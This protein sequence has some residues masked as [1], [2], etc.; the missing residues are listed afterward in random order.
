MSATQQQPQDSQY[1]PAG[2]Q[3]IVFEG[4]STLNTQSARPS[5]EDDQ[6][7]WMDGFMP[8]GKSTARTMWDVGPVIYS[9]ASG[10]H[11]VWFD[12]CNIGAVPIA[13]LFLS[14]GSIAVVYTTTLYTAIIAPPGT[15][16]NVSRMAAGISQW[17]D[18]FL[19]IVSTQANGYFLWDGT[20]F[21]SAGDSVPGFTTMPTGIMGSSAEVYEGRLWISNGST[22]EFSAPQSLTDFSSAD[23]GGTFQ[24]TDSFLRVGFTQLRQTNGF[25]YLLADS[26]INYISGV[27]TGG[28]PTTTTFSNQNADPE[29]GTPWSA[30]VDVFSRNIVFANAFGAHISYGGAVTKTSDALDGIYTSVPNF[31]GVTPSAA[32]AIVFS[33]RIWCLLLPVIDAVTGQQVN[34]LFCWDGKKWWSTQQSVALTYIQHQEI[35][36]VLTA[37]GTDGT[38]LYPL[39]AVPSANFTKTLQSKLYSKPGGW[40]YAKST[41]RFWGVAQYF[42]NVSTELGISI[43]NEIASNSNPIAI[44][45]NVLVWYN[46]SQANIAWLNNVNV[47]IEWS[48]S[49]SPTSGFVVFPPIQTAQNGVLLGFTV[50]TTCPDVAILGLSLSPQIEQYR[51]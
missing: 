23:G 39:F 47:P 35:N 2:P 1:G 40:M 27:T 29:T 15:I 19:I 31:G 16:L 18:Q 24:S 26:S 5:I 9:A 44:G 37:Y 14:D 38:S 10:V 51:G 42:S 49:G 21:Y 17:S 3:P 33:K 25:L 4:F 48:S 41:D 30:T 11:I 43:D 32:K 34:K 45:P 28:V 46:S 36:S 20:T 7:S 12:F 50:T 13:V 8:V 22:I 6:C